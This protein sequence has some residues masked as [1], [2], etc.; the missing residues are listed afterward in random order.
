MAT[1]STICWHFATTGI[2]GMVAA[3]VTQP[4]DVVKTRLQTQNVQCRATGACPS[5][6][7]QVRYS[8]LVSAPSLIHKQEG[9]RGFSRGSVPRLLFA[10]PSAAMCWGTYEV[11]A[12]YLRKTTE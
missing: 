4:L 9:V 11:T 1:T 7:V 2:S 3:M 5:P 6:A 10:A 12:K 8:G